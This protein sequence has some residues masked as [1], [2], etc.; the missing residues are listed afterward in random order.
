MGGSNVARQ[1]KKLRREVDILGRLPAHPNVVQFE[2]AFYEGDWLF[3]VMEIVAY[4]DL[5]AALLARSSREGVADPLS[6]ERPCFKEVET[7][8]VADQLA[9]GLSF[10]HGQGV[11]HRDLKP[12]NVLIASESREMA[13]IRYFVKIADFGLSKVI[14]D[15]LSEARSTVGTPIYIAPEV[16]ARGLSH[17]FPA[18]CWSLGIVL[19]VL[20]EGCFPYEGSP[21]QD[22]ATLTNR[23]TLLKVSDEAKSVVSG[24][25]VLSPERRMTLAEMQKH[26][27]FVD[28]E[29]VQTP[30]PKRQRLECAQQENLIATT[31]DLFGSS[32]S[33]ALSL[34]PATPMLTHRR[35]TPE[36]H[37]A[38]PCKI[39]RCDDGKAKPLDASQPNQLADSTQPGPPC[40]C[41]S[42]MCIRERKLDAG[43]FWGCSRF[44]VC[45]K[46]RAVDIACDACGKAMVK[47]SN[48]KSAEEFY[49]CS[50]FPSCRRTLGMHE[51]PPFC[52]LC[53]TVMILRS[54]KDDTTVQ[55]WGCQRFPTCRRTRAMR[56]PVPIATEMI[57]K[58]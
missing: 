9:N 22:Q 15:E 56:T 11:V 37:L 36:A 39:S 46:T 27:W 18:D 7:R 10:L 58:Q 44:P 50:G 20:L 40:E 48:R 14:G 30:Q 47:R 19:F 49:G 26:T 43:Q 5:M 57:G 13:Y 33:K 4:G 1:F 34:R 28:A 54:K 24:L 52:E 12:E 23:I 8:I 3:F 51:V 32:G 25:L 41:G 45:Q 17:G 6:R 29:V 42:V 35:P 2:G 55:F 38:P 53:N 31:E 21:G 16:M